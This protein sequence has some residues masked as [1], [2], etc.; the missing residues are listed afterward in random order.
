MND[1]R[2]ELDERVLSSAI[3]CDAVRVSSAGVLELATYDVDDPHE[4]PP[5]LLLEPG[6]YVVVEY[7]C[8]GELVVRVGPVEGRRAA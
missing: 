4:P 3:A 6:E 2:D 8:N 7:A 1:E 5:A